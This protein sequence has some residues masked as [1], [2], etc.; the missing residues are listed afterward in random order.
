ML[1]T[2]LRQNFGLIALATALLF[3]S[4]SVQ[5]KVSVKSKKQIS[6]SPLLLNLESWMRWQEATSI[7]RFMANI[8]MPGTARGSVMASP[9]K[10]SP[11]Y[12]YHWTRD[13]AV[14][15]NTVVDLADDAIASG[16]KSSLNVYLAALVDYVDFSIANQR[17]VTLTGLGEPKFEADGSAFN[18]GWCRPQNDGPALRASTLIRFANRLLAS[19]QKAYVAKK[20]Y[21]GTMASAV[22]ADLEYV[23]H[24]W[25]DANCEPWEEVA[26]HHFYNQLVQE[27]ALKDGAE[28]ATALD[29][30]GAA[31]WYASQAEAI[32]VELQ[33]Y[34]NPS[35]GAFVPTLVQTG[36]LQGKTSGLDSATILAVLHT[37]F[38]PTRAP[39]IGFNDSRFISTFEALVS[40]F[41]PLYSVNTNTVAANVGPAIG[42][43][44]EDVY[45]GLGFAN[46]NPWVLITA[47]FANASYR[48][49]ENQMQAGSPAAAKAWLA[50]GDSF[51]ERVKLHANADGS[52][53]EQ[54]DRQTGYMRGARDLT[55]S[56]VEV[57]Q[58]IRTRN[59]V[60]SL[61]L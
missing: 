33:K 61:I 10:V 39:L 2:L 58:A 45:D 32:S 23:S 28:L 57:I 36:G 25:R 59:R 42:R 47:A 11:N 38:E 44:P 5:A 13:A 40:A 6:T 52:L 51:M 9:E 18:A 16:T 4:P 8:S 15:M 3:S 60:R 41:Q 34:F 1:K 49:A 12:F 46:G 24:H 22:K 29:D 37:S 35:T 55:W 26:G 19:G 31:N 17:T 50:R 14:T 54:I 53:S 43:Y 7:E 48:I 21:D 27:R 30:P 20:L 56:H